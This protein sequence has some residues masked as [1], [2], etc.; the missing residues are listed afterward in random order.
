MR[1]PVGVVDEIISL[2]IAF[3]L[4]YVGAVILWNVNPFF[5]VLFVLAALYIVLRGFKGNVFE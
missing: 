5:A 1:P 2:L 4:I 3:V